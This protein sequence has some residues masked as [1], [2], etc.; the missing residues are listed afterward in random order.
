MN[1]I[2]KGELHMINYLLH[3]SISFFVLGSLSTFAHETFLPN[4]NGKYFFNPNF[5]ISTAKENKIIQMR[6]PNAQQRVSVLRGLG[7]VCKTQSSLI[8]KC[9]RFIKDAISLPSHLK[10]K[11]QQMYAG[12]YLDFS[13][14][15]FDWILTNDSEFLKQWNKRQDVVVFGVNIG[16]LKLSSI[17]YLQLKDID[18]L[19]IEDLWINIIGGQLFYRTGPFVVEKV[20]TSA[21]TTET[22]IWVDF[23]IE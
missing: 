12:A 20:V 2:I 8:V 1:T 19:K 15:S 14:S 13:S 16:P 17:D 9:S 5:L 23:P 6:V 22:S 21:E 11:L 4:F 18:K 7:Y 10:E 3:L